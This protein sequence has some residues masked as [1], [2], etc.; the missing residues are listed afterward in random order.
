[1][2][3]ASSGTVQAISLPQAPARPRFA[4]GA[5]GS[6]SNAVAAE[7]FEA[8]AIAQFLKPMFH[9]MGKA[10]APFGGGTTE[11]QFQPFLIDAIAK[12]MEARGGLGLKPMIENAM[13]IDEAGK[14]NAAMPARLRPEMSRITGD[15][16]GKGVRT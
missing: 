2:P 7:K 8:M 4:A 13:A 12:S 16:D 14:A 11:R 5:A 10:D 1:M 9:D 15:G 3:A 6:A